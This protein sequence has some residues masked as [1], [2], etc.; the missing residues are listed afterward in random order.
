M[1]L[2]RDC[3]DEQL[4][5]RQKRPM[6]RVDGIILVLEPGR[7]PRRPGS[8][9]PARRMRL[10]SRTPAGMFTRSRLTVRTAPLPWQVG[11]GSSI[12]VPAPPHS[13]QGWEIENMP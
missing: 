12:T 10:P 7:Q 1:D 5:D 3:L 11:Q 13:E 6:G 4:L 2:I 9:L 8:P